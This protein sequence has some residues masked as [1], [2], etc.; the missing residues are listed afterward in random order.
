MVLPLAPVKNRGLLYING[1][2]FSIPKGSTT[3]TV[4]SGACRDSTNINDIVLGSDVVVDGN[5][6]GV[7]GVDEAPIEAGFFYGLYIIASSQSVNTSAN[8]LGGGPSPNPLGPVGAPAPVNPYPT[9]ALLSKSIVGDNLILPQG[10]DMY[11]RIG[12]VSTRAGIGPEPAV[13]FVEFHVYG[14]GDERMYYYDEPIFYPN[15]FPG[16]VVYSTQQ[17]GA[18]PPINSSAL[19]TVK[20]T[21]AAAT[22][23]VEFIPPD[24]LSTGNGPVQFGCGVAGAQVGTFYIPYELL[25]GG[26]VVSSFRYRTTG[27]GDSWF[28]TVS[29]F[30]DYL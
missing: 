8:D 7:N 3:L 14:N 18:V 24:S 21:P 25:A 4:R 22:N 5:R 10:Y 16:S 1:Y 30:I 26:G 12:W 23:I 6:V 19:I 20:Y 17:L 29:G 2:D 15:P 27:A 28:L 13:V 9:A 11:R